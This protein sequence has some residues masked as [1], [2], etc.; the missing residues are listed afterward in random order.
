M[1]CALR[2]LSELEGAVQSTR[3]LVSRERGRV[4]VAAPP[5]SS[6]AL[7]PQA[8]AEFREAF[9]N[10]AIMLQDVMF[11]E[12]S[13]RVG[14]G[15]FDCGIGAFDTRDDRLDIQPLVRERLLLTCP[16]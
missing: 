11:E 4:T 13:S 5:L 10:I 14:A 8:I 1:P 3:T 12:I 2:V 16:P 6:T 9:P 15:E 7:L